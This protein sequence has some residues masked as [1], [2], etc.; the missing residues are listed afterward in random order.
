MPADLV[1]QLPYIDRVCEAFR[2]P[3]ISLERFEADDII[4]TLSK[5]AAEQGLEVVIVTVD[6]DMFQLVDDKVSILDTRTNKMIDPKGVEEKWDVR[7]DQVVDLLSL[8]G[9][10]SDNIPGAP[11]I[12]D[13]G[14]RNLIGEFGSLDQ[15]LERSEEVSRKSYRTSLQENSSLILKSRELI[16][17][18]TDLPIELDLPKLAIST[19]NQP[20]LQEL[21]KELNFTRLLQEFTPQEEFDVQLVTVKSGK[22]IRDLAST[23][24]G[25]RVA[26]AV[27]H[28]GDGHG[29]GTIEGIAF[30][31]GDQRCWF[32]SK[33]L[34]HGNAEILKDLFSLETEWV[35]HDLKSFVL[36]S[37]K[38]G[39]LPR[40]TCMDT[41]LMAYLLNPN[42]KD[43]SLER[44]CTELLGIKL[45]KAE[46]SLIG[47]DRPSHLC[48]KA[49]AIFRLAKELL[50]ELAQKGLEKL[51][52]EI[53]MPL[54]VV[55]A[56]MEAL[57]VRVDTERLTRMSAEM[58]VDISQL[59]AAI[60]SLAGENFN[61]NSPKQL[62]YVL[63]EKLKLP[64][65][66]KTGKAGHYSTGVEVLEEL[67]E[68]QDIA[69]KILEF[70]EVTKLKNTY[71]D[72][73]PKLVNP[74]TGRIHT[75][76]NQMVAATGRL[77]SSNP[78]LQ[79]IPIRSELG[80]Q[81]RRAFIPEEGF[82]ILAADYSQIELRVMA[83]LSE[84]RVLIE[85]FRNGEDIHSRTA[86]EVFGTDSGI[87]PHELRRRAK[88]IN[89]GIMYGLSAF[90]LAKSL[91]IS[92][93]EAQQFIND[94]F[95]RYEGVRRWTEEVVEEARRD[96]Y[97]KTL[98]GRIRPIPEINNKNR[99]LQEFAR[100]TAVNAPIQGTAADLIKMAMVKIHHRLNQEG[101]KSR[102]I[103]QV[104]DELVL[105]VHQSEVDA[106]TNLVRKGMEGIASLQ[107]PLKVDLSTG[108]SWYEA[109]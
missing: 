57:G 43:F 82:T 109:K 40:G 91:K 104:H 77:S 33:E 86:S 90:G 13:K 2:I 64:A 87:D 1:E 93:A 108:S 5:K 26:V 27:W 36:G 46:Y 32:I 9:D 55:L 30:N 89:F 49:Q 63:F 105:E 95:K 80:R 12:G 62:S 98:F 71:L 52:H 76:Y 70:R 66:K 48:E 16:R 100:R 72:A 10:A 102:I 18:H 84:D 94:Y 24:K 14:A 11:G 19:P 45:E 79:N 59:E 103:L 56:D 28:E 29:A 65:P 60:F 50:P 44:I 21:F 99:N 4:G 96:G 37:R 97:V 67:A 68:T 35:F 53:E 42:N 69:R 85:A 83:H 38:R 61:V 74:E 31:K 17:I 75:S 88:V 92:R 106:A 20:A 7:P 41:M 6:K 25:S 51:F 47:G 39:W 15:L 3:V 101:C 81:T 23:F 34:I 73:L 22:A 8:I 58:E 54:V 78:N 107:V